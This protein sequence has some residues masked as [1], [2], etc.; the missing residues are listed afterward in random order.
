MGYVASLV[1]AEA[2]ATRIDM[3][4][5][6]ALVR[7]LMAVAGVDEEQAASVTCNLIWNDLAGR[8][9]HGVER[10]PILLKRVM[11]GLIA[12]PPMLHETPLSP[13]AAL[14]D[15]G[16]GFG[17]HAG[18]VAMERAIGIARDQGLG[19]VGVR[20]SNFYGTGAY[21]VQMAADQGM[22]GLALSNSYAKVAAHGGTAP[23]LGTNPLAFG[24][25]RRDGRSLLVD[26]STAGLAGSTLRAAI[27]DGDDLPV[28]LLVA[29]DGAPVTDPAQAESATLL[30]AAGAKG[31]GLALMVEVLAGVLTGAG[32]SRQV[33]SLYRDFERGG[34][35]GHFFLAL[36][37][38]RWMP[39][40]DF[41]DRMEMMVAMVCGGSDTR[42]PGELRWD[43]FD[44]NRARGIP[45]NATT[46]QVLRGL[47]DDLGVDAGALSA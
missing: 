23:V 34:D 10:L 5:L 28:G 42:L 33:G 25:P 31:F 24:A 7:H 40:G 18:R 16:N 13:A 32:I 29:P 19:A 4:D 37:V 30:P 44:E 8:H 39:G 12:C 43:R 26:M 41:L 20:N 46:T 14:I 22:I 45:L 1:G 47:A 38:A 6:R 9:N 35:S 11:A 21:F 2:V 15:A 17:Q 27:R 36:D 3:G